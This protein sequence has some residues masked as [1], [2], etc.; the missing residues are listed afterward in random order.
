MPTHMNLFY[1]EMEAAMAGVQ[2][3][4]NL[5][6]YHGITDIFS[7]N[8]GKVVQVAVAVG[9]DIVPGRMG[10]DARD[11]LG[12]EYEMKTLDLAKKTR[13]FSTNHHLN[14][15]TIA[16]FR[17]RR[18]VF[19]TYGGIVLQEAFMVLP[20]DMEPL[21]EKWTRML[22]S[23]DHINNPKIPLDYVRDVGTVMYLKDVAPAW[24]EGKTPIADLVDA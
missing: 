13:G 9:L 3:L 16:K 1:A 21:Y 7:D 8:G 15:G 4:Q 24:M 23:Q 12:N 10:A 5:A 18:F 17:S 19:A 20:E 6:Q 22:K 14:L 2:K 11:R